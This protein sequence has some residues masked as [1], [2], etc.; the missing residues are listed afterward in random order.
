M[1]PLARHLWFIR[2][3]IVRLGGQV[4]NPTS[5]VGRTVAANTTRHLREQY[6]NADPLLV[7]EKPPEVV[8][9]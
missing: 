7:P 6:F 9:P 2:D 3:S 8:V 5:E 1:S 4:P